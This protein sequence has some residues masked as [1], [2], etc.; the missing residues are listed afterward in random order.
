MCLSIKYRGCNLAFKIHNSKTYQSIFL[1]PKSIPYAPP[2]VQCVQASCPLTVLQAPW[3]L[4]SLC[5]LLL[6][7]SEWFY[8][9]HLFQLFIITLQDDNHIC[10][11]STASLLWPCQPRE[12]WQKSLITPGMFAFKSGRG[13][14]WGSYPL[15]NKTIISWREDIHSLDFFFFSWKHIAFSL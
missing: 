9:T 2:T 5:V 10:I 6:F 4:H 14:R 1:I 13:V 3:A 11:L 12:I 7:L 8:F 15:L